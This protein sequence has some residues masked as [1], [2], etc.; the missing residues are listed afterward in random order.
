MAIRFA[1]EIHAH[2][3]SFSRQG[4]DEVF[5]GL[6]GGAPNTFV[7]ERTGVGSDDDPLMP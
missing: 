3:A 2:L 4:A 1:K 5:D 7:G 6:K